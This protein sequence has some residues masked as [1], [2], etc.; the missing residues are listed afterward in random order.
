MPRHGSVASYIARNHSEIAEKPSSRPDIVP[1]I[2]GDGFNSYAIARTYHETYGGQVQ[3]VAADPIPP[4]T[5]SRF[6]VPH[7]VADLAND[8]VV[9]RALAAI[10]AATPGKHRIILGAYVGF[11]RFLRRNRH[12]LEQN[13]DLALADDDALDKVMDK[14]DFSELCD[15]VNLPS[16]Y[17]Y[18]VEMGKEVPVKFDI[19]FP[20]VAR[21]VRWT[22]E[23]ARAMNVFQPVFVLN[24]SAEVSELWRKLEHI[25]YD[26]DFL[27]RPF[28]P[29]TAPDMRYLMLY[30]NQRG[31]VTLAACLRLLY[32]APGPDMASTPLCFLSETPNPSDL[33]RATEF[34]KAADYHGF[35]CFWLMDDTA[36]GMRLFVDARPCLGAFSFAMARGGV[37]PMTHLVADI[38]D[39]QELPLEQTHDDELVCSLPTWYLMRVVESM[40]IRHLISRLS[41]RGHTFNALSYSFDSSLVRDTLTR[42]YMMGMMRDIE[43]GKV[44]TPNTL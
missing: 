28:I 10:A 31:D 29:A 5:H 24:D 17:M 26:N 27:I 12:V 40:K 16:P 7:L 41:Q 42:L 18:I 13:F 19:P 38:I 21:P 23:D 11:M 20:V 37:N 4:L 32:V 25:G 33:E 1:V 30:V 34:V 15:D 8:E 39:G 6:I 44:L 14:R 9:L 2:V 36:H 3:L 43:Q 35:V 22:I